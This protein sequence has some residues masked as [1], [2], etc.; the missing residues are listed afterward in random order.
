M[1]ATD[2]SPST[3][4][5]REPELLRAREF[6]DLLAIVPSMIG[7]RA[8]D[9]LVVVPFLGRRAGGGFRLPLPDRLRRS[10]IQALARGC[11]GLMAAV[12]DADAALAVVYTSGTFE[13][14]RG[15]PLLDLGRA[16]L[17][18]LERTDL[19]IVGV[20]CVAA[21]GWGRYTIPAESRSPRPLSEL[22]GSEAGILARAA[23][24][25]PLDV[26]ALAGLPDVSA[27]DRAIVAAVLDRGPG[28]ALDAISMVE[29]WLA[30]PPTAGQDARIIRVMQSPALRDRITIQIALGRGAAEQSRRLQHRLEAVQATTGESM[31][32]IVERETAASDVDEHALA[33]AALMMGTGAGPDRHRVERATASLA[34][35]AALAPREARPPVLTVLAWCWWALGVASLAAIHLESALRIDPGYS[36]AQLYRTVFA[37]RSL[38][39]WVVGAA[40][41]SL[42]AA[43]EHP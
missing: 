26:R 4:P 24:P 5:A 10:E 9:S 12:R 17:R 36:M 41:E 29:R 25:D 28:V 34:R 11:T 3:A 23:T 37:S 31:D 40:S 15:I 2:R 8:E 27:A 20:A 19:G 38:P 30:S 35:L 42:V 21:D 13:Q 16:V 43:S 32:E 39:D 33:S 1:T 14:S 6:A 18:R 22:E 7:M